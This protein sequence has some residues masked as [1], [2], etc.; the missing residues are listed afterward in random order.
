VGDTDSFYQI[1][2]GLVRVLKQWGLGLIFFYSDF[3]HIFQHSIFSVPWIELSILEAC[4]VFH[5]NLLKIYVTDRGR[6]IK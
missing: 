3:L 1:A 6:K 2:V 5:Q 4:A